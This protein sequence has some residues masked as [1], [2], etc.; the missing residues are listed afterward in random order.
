MDISIVEN[1]LITKKLWPSEVWADFR[2]YLSTWGVH[3]CT[4]GVLGRSPIHG[5][6]FGVHW[7]YYAADHRSLK[8]YARRTPASPK[9]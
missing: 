9:P 5:S 1:G 2:V 4:R 6:Y 7:A 3:K 8:E